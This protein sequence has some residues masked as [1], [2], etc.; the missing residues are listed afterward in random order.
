MWWWYQADI[1]LAGSRETAVV[2]AVSETD[3]YGIEDW[4]RGQKGDYRFGAL[5]DNTT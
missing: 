1:D 4:C 2:A 3:E 5:V